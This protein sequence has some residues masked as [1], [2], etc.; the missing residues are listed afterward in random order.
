MD[1]DKCYENILDGSA[2]VNPPPLKET[3]S[4]NEY[5]LRAQ[6]KAEFWNKTADMNHLCDEYVRMRFQ[7]S[8][9]QME[10]QRTSTTSDS[11][12]LVDI[13]SQQGA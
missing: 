2:I 9:H 12:N 4:T 13:V 3:I 5:E 10:R 11:A 6:L 1:N 7:L 8:M